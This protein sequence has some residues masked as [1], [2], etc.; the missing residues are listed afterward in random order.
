MNMPIAPLN[1]TSVTDTGASLL[2]SLKHLGTLDVQNTKVSET[3]IDR[4]YNLHPGM[5]VF[6]TTHAVSAKR[7]SLNRKP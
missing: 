5:S 2:E 1:Q 4:I 7:L 3:A 6:P